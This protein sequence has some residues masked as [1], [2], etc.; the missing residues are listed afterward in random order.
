MIKDIRTHLNSSYVSYSNKLRKRDIIQ[1]YVED[2]IDK[3]F[4]YVYLHPYESAHHCSFRISTLRDR[5]KILKGKASLLNYKQQEDLGHYMWLCIDS[6]YDELIPNY[7]NFS[8]RIRCDDYVITTY[9]Y[10]IES[11]KCTPDLLEIDILKASLADSCDIDVR[12]LLQTISLLYKKMFLLLLEMEEK[13][14]SRFRIDDFCRN[15]SFVCF[16]NEK[17]D[18]NQIAD[19][20]NEWNNEHEYLYRQYENKFNSWSAKLKKLGFD[21]KEYY[22][23]YNG[24]GM[25]EKIAI[26]LVRFYANKYRKSQLNAICNGSDKKDRKANLVNEYYNNTFTSLSDFR[27]LSTRVKQLIIDNQP[28]MTNSASLRINAQIEKALSL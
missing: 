1:V 27:S 7:S 5:D 8:A 19:K 24:H 20:I 28:N 15:L 9:W 14:D 13:H 10:S 18:V 6:D 22:Q 12:E 17:L 21:E 11:L 26:P 25:L 16:N 23:L 4:W 2:E 3:I